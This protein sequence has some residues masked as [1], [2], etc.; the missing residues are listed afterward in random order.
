M[1]IVVADDHPMFREGICLMLSRLYTEAIVEQTGDMAGVRDALAQE[2]RPDLLVIDLF[3]PGF[4][5]RK[6]LKA[7]RQRLPL[8]PIV[9]ISML[10]DSDEV[11]GIMDA[12]INGF[13]SKAVRPESISTAIVD[14]MD[15]E[16]VVLMGSAAATPEAMQ[17]AGDDPLASLSG[18]QLD[19][20][21]LIV[22][23]QSN[24]EIA[25]ELGLSPYTVRIHVSAMLK[26]LGV[27]SRAAAASLAASRGF[28]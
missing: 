5:F 3:F 27:A 25:R 16:T 9:V 18:R 26:A 23:G 1:R 2:R 22:R 10:Q 24:K 4:E 17:S 7:L 13:V 15:G 19:V 12:G 14:V 8:T 21:R 11:R 6:D 28:G 20:L